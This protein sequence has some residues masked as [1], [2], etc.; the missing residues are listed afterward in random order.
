MKI[1]INEIV[2]GRY[3]GVAPEEFVLLHK[4]QFKIY[5]ILKFGKSG[6]MT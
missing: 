3:T 5:K 2:K 1:S 4:K 6:K